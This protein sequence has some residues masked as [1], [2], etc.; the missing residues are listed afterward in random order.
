[1]RT[2]LRNLCLAI[3]AAAAVTAC[4]HGSEA[5]GTAT[6][7]ATSSSNEQPGGAC[8]LLTPEQVNTVVPESDGGKE[9]DASA[10]ALLKDVE[11]KYCRYFHVEGT[12]MKYLDLLVYEASSDEGFKQIKI[13]AWAHQG[14][15]RRLD[16]GDIG[17]LH[18]MSSQNE[19]VAT[20][21]KGR[22]VFELKLFANDAADKTQQLIDLAN[23][24]AG[25]I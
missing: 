25:K 6:Q 16:I 17:F 13:G 18:D 5:P 7:Q 24:V 11:I 9:Q 14:S 15:S 23:I 21:S 22:T 19:M 1:M 4:S 12:D 10:A 20:A 8:S 3:G 2:S